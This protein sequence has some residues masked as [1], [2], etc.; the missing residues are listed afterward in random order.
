MSRLHAQVAVVYTWLG[1]NAEINALYDTRNWADGLAPEDVDPMDSV[2]VN[3]ALLNTRLVF[4]NVP[5]TA[6]LYYQLFVNQLTISG[7]TRG[8]ILYGDYDTT[9]IGD[10]GIVY[11]PAGAVTSTIAGSI[12]LEES[13]TWNIASGTLVLKD[14]VADSYFDYTTSTM[15]YNLAELTKTG[16]GVLELHSSYSSE[17]T[18]GFKLSQGSVV[19]SPDQGLEITPFG[20]GVLTFDGGV[21]I[22]KAQSYYGVYDDSA[23]RITSNDIVSNG[24]IT[25]VNGVALHLGNHGVDPTTIELRADTTVNTSGAPLY[26]D[27]NIIETGGARKLTLDGTGALV[28]TGQNAYSGG[29]HVEKGLLIF[30]NVA[31]LPAAPATNMLTSAAAGYIGFGDNGSTN[32]GASLTNPQGLFL[33]RFNKASALGIIGFD[34]DPEGSANNFSGSIN[35]TGFAASAKLGSATTAIL[36]G[37]ITPQGTA[38]RFGGGGGYLRIDSILTNG[39][40]SRSLV[41]DSPAAHPL[42]VRLT[43]SGNA[44]SGGTTVTNSGLLLGS[45]ASYNPGLPYGPGSITINAGGYVGFADWGDQSQDTMILGSLGVINAASVGAVGFEFGSNLAAPVDLSGFAGPL[46]LG[47]SVLGYIDDGFG[48]GIRVTSAITPAGGA[49]APYRFAGYKGG[50]LEIATALTGANGIHVGDPNSVGTFG[51][52]QYGEYSTVALTGNNAGLSGNVVLYGGQ[53]GVGQA[54]GTVGID[55]TNAL[56]SGS[57]IVQGMTLPTEW[58]DPTTGAFPRPRLVVEDFDTIIPNVVTLN[59]DLEVGGY[60]DFELSGVISGAGGIHIED[61]I[62]LTLAGNNTFSGGV[63]LHGSSSLLLQHDHASGSGLLKFGGSSYASVEFGTATPILG[64]LASYSEN[65]YAELSATLSNTVITLN[66]NTDSAFNGEFRS[67]IAAP[68]DNTRVVKSGTGLLRLAQGGLYYYNGTPE[69]SLPGTP[70]VSLQVNQGTLILGSAFYLEGSAPTVWVHGGTLAVEGG[71]SIYNPIVIDNGGKLAGY[72]YFSSDLNI[73]AGATLSPGY[74]FS[75]G[76][77]V[78]LMRFEHLGL[79]PGGTMEWDILRADPTAFAWDVV[80][81]YASSTLDFTG[82]NLLDAP[83][84]ATRFTLKVISRQLNGSQGLLA[85]FNPSQA[86]S[87]MIFDTSGIAGFDPAKVIL[88]TSLFSN[89]LDAG[90]GSGWFFLSQEGNQLKLNFSPVPEPSTYALLASGLALLGLGHRRR[91]NAR[92]GSGAGPM[93][94]PR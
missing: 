17:W 30:L 91:R 31:S 68:G 13:Q 33:D 27:G 9:H 37:L 46:Y 93:P 52:F 80:E 60:P 51:D 19:I 78:G 2:A 83:S 49:A 14:W 72:G 53:L 85:D 45:D 28:L 81:V 35:L 15:V 7:N 69:A 41:L 48:S 94:L 50:Q 70:N 18:G 63:Y 58:S 86:Y 1:S 65:D 66:Q 32:S 75:G 42:T 62:R 21:L 34:S 59:T 61:D 4:G 29:T 90:A 20:T 3:N 12:Q 71:N 54:N 82:I 57:L 47:S 5:S 84:A 40:G 36:S 92:R 23:A 44:F 24:A 77:P 11:T 6:P 43:N 87:W 39:P 10:G 89:S 22:A 55:P 25:T 64:G 79:M 56:G 67:L 8:Y 74:G 88:D 16:A 38:Y 73:G 76:N 26:L